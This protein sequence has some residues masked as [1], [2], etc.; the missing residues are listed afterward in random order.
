MNMVDLFIPLCRQ[1]FFFLSREKLPSAM[2]N[3]QALERVKAESGTDT[4]MM[5]CYPTGKTKHRRHFWVEEA[6]ASEKLERTSSGRM[7]SNVLCWSKEGKNETGGLFGRAHI[8][9][10][11]LVLVQDIA[12]TV[13]Y[14]NGRDRAFCLATPSTMLVLVADDVGGDP[15]GERHQLVVGQRVV[16]PR[17]R[18]RRQQRVPHALA[19]GAAHVRRHRLGAARRALQVHLRLAPARGRRARR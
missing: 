15:A 6:N 17:R 13:A 3:K 12:P 1:L 8:K 19:H 16:V 4:E 11:K 5:L 9:R 2:A 7:L 10:E 14:R 18:P